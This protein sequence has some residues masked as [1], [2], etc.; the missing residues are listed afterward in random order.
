MLEGSIHQ[1]D[2]KIINISVPHNRAPKYKKQ[3]WTELK[4]K[5]DNS[6]IIAGH[7]NTT[8]LIMDK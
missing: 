7:F 4:G 6:I 8:L 1:D 2:I 3:K 5:V